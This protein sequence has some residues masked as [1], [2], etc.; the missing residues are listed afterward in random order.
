MDKPEFSIPTTFMK[1]AR[2]KMK[3]NNDTEAQPATPDEVT[4]KRLI[5]QVGAAAAVVVGASLALTYILKRAQ[6][7]T[8]VTPEDET[9][10][11]D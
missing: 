1:N 6:E 7:K 11:E 5:K 3:P 4:A 2:A 10:E 9:T 8:P